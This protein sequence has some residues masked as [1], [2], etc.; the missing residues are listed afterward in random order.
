MVAWATFDSGF[1]YT[2]APWQQTS[3]MAGANYRYDSY[4]ITSTE[5][6]SNRT[7]AGAYRATGRTQAAFALETLVDEI[8]EQL[9]VSP[10]DL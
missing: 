10:I 2:H 6:L 5:T 7:S 9:G 1:F 4:E 3:V 8:A